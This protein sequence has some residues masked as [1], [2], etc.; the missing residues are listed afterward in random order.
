MIQRDLGHAS[1]VTNAETYIYVFRKMDKEAV[2]ASAALL[3]SHAKTHMSLEG[4]S[5]A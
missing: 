2:R 5:Q 3:L 1:P 4:A